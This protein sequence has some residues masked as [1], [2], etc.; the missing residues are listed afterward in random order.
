MLRSRVAVACT[1][2]LVSIAA[3]FSQSSSQASVIVAIETAL[4]EI[5]LA[6]DVAHAPVTAANFLRYVDGRFYD[7]GQINRAVR[8][9]NERRHDVEIQCIQFQINPARSRD[10]FAPIPLERTRDTGVKHLDGT[11]S[12]ARSTP[13]SATASFDIVIGD[14]PE[15]DFGGKRNADGQGFAAFGRVVAG[16][17]V[18]KKIQTS[19]T[20]QRGAYGTETLTPPVAIVRAYRKPSK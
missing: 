14:Q 5:D 18:V 16:M 3:A 9:D 1:L 20:G 6:V 19:P 13:D 17:D 11:A 8:L 10:E 7:G 12:M 2:L 4:G 15:M